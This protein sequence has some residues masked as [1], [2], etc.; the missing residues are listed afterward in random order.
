MAAGRPYAFY[1]AACSL[2]EMAACNSD[3]TR[4]SRWALAQY[5]ASLRSLATRAARYFQATDRLAASRWAAGAIKAK[6]AKAI[7]HSVTHEA[8]K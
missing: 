7:A 1:F 3:I 2:R 4:G 6:A 5:W 8:S